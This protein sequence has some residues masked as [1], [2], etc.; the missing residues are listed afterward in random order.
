MMH[1]KNQTDRKKEASLA[2]KIQ[3]K[4]QAKKT[5]QQLASALFSS[6]YE[7]EKKH[8]YMYHLMQ[9]TP[10]QSFGY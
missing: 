2:C 4:C 7:K 1:G 6:P 5:D 3:K 9:N 8:R 10:G